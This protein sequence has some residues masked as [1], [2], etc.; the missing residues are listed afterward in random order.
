MLLQH[1]N[2]DVFRS[3]QASIEMHLYTCLILKLVS[4]TSI[5]IHGLSDI[6]LVDPHV[7]LLRYTNRKEIDG[8]VLN[9]AAAIK[10]ALAHYQLKLVTKLRYAF[11]EVRV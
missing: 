5:H 8:F 7:H 3:Y 10:L 9:C 1:P 4:K 11:N 2:Q 6:S